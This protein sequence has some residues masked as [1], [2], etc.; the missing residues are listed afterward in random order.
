[1]P[2][3][4]IDTEE[5]SSRKK[6]NV[7]KSKQKPQPD[8]DP[9]PPAQKDDQQSQTVS[10]ESSVD[11]S[12]D[13]LE[14]EEKIRDNI[15]LDKSSERA[16]A[17]MDAIKNHAITN[18]HVFSE[19]F[20][21]KSK[22]KNSHEWVYDKLSPIAG[23]R[24]DKSDMRNWN[25]KS[26]ETDSS[27]L[28]FRVGDSNKYTHSWAVVIDTDTFDLK[29]GLKDNIGAVSI[30]RQGVKITL[31]DKEIQ[32]SFQS[33][34]FIK[35]Q[36]P[37]ETV[38]TIIK[39]GVVLPPDIK[40]KFKSFGFF[41]LTSLN[42]DTVMPPDFIL[43]HL[44]FNNEL[45]L[46]ADKVVPPEPGQSRLDKIAEKIDAN[47][48]RMFALFTIPL[49]VNEKL[50]KQMDQFSDELENMTVKMKKF[51]EG[52]KLELIKTE[53]TDRLGIHRS[54]D[55]K[56]EIE[57]V[58]DKKDQSKSYITMKTT[59][60]N[61][62]VKVSIPANNQGNVV[63][64]FV[65]EERRGEK[66]EFDPNDDEEVEKVAESLKVKKEKLATHRM[67]G[68]VILT[69]KLF[70][71]KVDDDTEEQELDSRESLEKMILV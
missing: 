64:E 27:K 70:S 46:A 16:I 8:S 29:T 35:V 9:L 69:G 32:K 5:N 47:F 57:F 2:G 18:N 26:E 30:E 23:N 52:W 12:K 7:D 50:R 48:W 13:H 3:L 65:S 37:N 17:M 21:I 45:R 19:T 54:D 25:I 38:P 63:I 43:E 28:V 67:V 51:I 53:G 11:Y 61:E 59:F 14:I 55:N 31:F 1:M 56:S 40:S 49:T 22:V 36:F 68:D 4:G 58:A 24:H 15:K 41:G 60:G 42:N 62:E 66:V 6:Q 39:V 44:L 10:S 34:D 71:N 33:G 20:V